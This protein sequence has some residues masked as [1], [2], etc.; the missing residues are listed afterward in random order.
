MSG[1]G[2]GAKQRDEL[3]RMCALENTEFYL[4]SLCDEHLLTWYLLPMSHLAIDLPPLLPILLLE[5]SKFSSVGK[6]LLCALFMLEATE[7]VSKRRESD[8]G[9]KARTTSEATSD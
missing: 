8:S 6:A 7:D 1:E 4:A 5:R 9:E 2:R 3:K